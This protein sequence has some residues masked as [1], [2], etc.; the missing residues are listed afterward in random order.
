MANPSASAVVRVRRARSRLLDWAALL[1]AIAVLM[2]SGS[3]LASAT[4]TLAR[5]NN[6]DTAAV[7]VGSSGIGDAASPSP[8]PAGDSDGDANDW[9]GTPLVFVG[10][11]AV[12]VVV[13]GVI[14]A[15]YRSHRSKEGGSTRD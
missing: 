14:V 5:S 15:R 12:A 11:L 2:V 1:A 9:T 4:A 6:S 13:T 3:S 7:I 10:L 8:L